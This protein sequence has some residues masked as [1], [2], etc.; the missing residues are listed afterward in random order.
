MAFDNTPNKLEAVFIQR[1]KTN[2]YYEEINISASNAIV[3]LDE[4]G[5]LTADNVNVWA[6]K[7]GIGGGGG[8]TPGGSYNIS[9]S[10]A[11]G[12]TSAS[13]ATTASYALNA[14]GGGV[15]PGGSYNI[16]TSYASGSISASYSITASYA[17]NAG[18]TQDSCS[19]ASSSLSASHLNGTVSFAESASWASSSIS[20]SYSLTSSVIPYNGNR[21][22]KRSPYTTLNVGGTTLSSFIEN[23]FFPFIPATVNISSAGTT[24]YETGSTQNFSITSTVTANDETSFGSASILRNSIVWNIT[25]SPAPTS[26]TFTDTGISSSY[27]YVTYVQTDNNGSPTVINSS[28]K[29]ASFIFPYL[30]GM[31][32]TP[33]L[34]GN[35]L[36]TAFTRQVVA[37][38]NKTVNMVG[39]VTYIY[40]AYPTSYAILTSILDPSSFESIGNFEYSASVPVTSSGL[41]N[42]WMTTYRVYRTALVSDPNGNYQFKH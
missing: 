19:W 11:S 33:G 1:D 12:S 9:T 14:G 34:S 18:G 13:Y 28:T 39:N 22:I 6:T 16:S 15:I 17:L 35:A 27:S 23:F 8:V 41:T 40:F 21:L 31:S 36:Y 5:S 29:A 20:S 42:N 37:D 38:G 30:W 32:T 26:F 3:Y 7:Y 4:T 25:G 24:L 10:Y 2:Q